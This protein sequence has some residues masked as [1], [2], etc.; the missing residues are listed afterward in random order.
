MK[1]EILE[2]FISE[3]GEI[4]FLDYGG[5]E[6]RSESTI[7]LFY[8][9]F[10]HIND[11]CALVQK[12]FY[13]DIGDISSKVEGHLTFGYTSSNGI[14]PCPDFTFDQWIEC[15][16][17]NYEETIK[18]ISDKGTNNYLINKLF[19]TGSLHTQALRYH[20]YELG[21][22]HPEKMEIIPMEWNKLYQK[23]SMHNYTSYVSLEDHTRY[24][25]LID[26][27]AAG[28][29]ARMK[30][31]LF[32]NRPLFLVSREEYKKEYFYNGLIPYQHFIPVKQDLSNLLLQLE[33]AENNYSYAMTI[34]N[35]A[36][37][38]AL[39][40]LNKQAVI[41]YLTKVILEN[42]TV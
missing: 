21:K 31:L 38:Y 40:N 4:S 32:S 11:K 7:R 29:S 26:S 25:Y 27:G 33:W 28:F 3:N 35:N 9:A 5:Y 24:K 42:C 1:Y 18:R 2:S 15:G 37:N 30:F 6:S 23:G 8:E 41:K 34:A 19:W 39:E 14:V 12:H 10:E 13:I 22:E 17:N 16:I 36:R 20:L